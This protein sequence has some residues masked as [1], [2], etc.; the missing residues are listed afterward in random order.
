MVRNSHLRLIQSLHTAISNQLGYVHD[1]IYIITFR[2]RFLA[3]SSFKM[4]V[5]PHILNKVRLVIRNSHFKE[6]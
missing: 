5:V 2:D 4:Q 6:E 1:D 3:N